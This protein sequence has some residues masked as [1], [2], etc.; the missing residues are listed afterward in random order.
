MIYMQYEDILY[1]QAS[2]EL[3]FLH[4]LHMP[5]R[6]L[7]ECEFEATGASETHDHSHWRQIWDK[8]S[9]RIDSGDLPHVILVLNARQNINMLRLPN[10]EPASQP[11]VAAQTRSNVLASYI[12]N[13]APVYQAFFFASQRT[14]E[15]GE[16]VWAREH[17]N[18]SVV[19]P[20]L[21]E[22]KLDSL[23]GSPSRAVKVKK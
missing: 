16:K 9:Y 4:G 2:Q 13:L 1:V 18:L 23:C 5:S 3:W 11:Q 15:W 10:S 12:S 19:S 17:S 6:V 21:I 22:H 8:S 7:A 14:C 20:P